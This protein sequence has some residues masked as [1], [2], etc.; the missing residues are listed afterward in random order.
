MSY[1]TNRR[2]YTD[3]VREQ[4]E[5]IYEM[6]STPPFHSTADALLFYINDILAKLLLIV[7]QL[8]YLLMISF[9]CQLGG[10]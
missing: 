7:M 1:F 10:I 2:Q 8:H 6:A 5:S 3:A 4:S 9:G